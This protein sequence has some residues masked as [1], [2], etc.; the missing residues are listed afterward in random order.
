MAWIDDYF[1]ETKKSLGGP[2]QSH[3]YSDSSEMGFQSQ[4]L[5]GGQA[6]F[7]PKS[8]SEIMSMEDAAISG[9]TGAALGGPA[10]AGIMV[11]G[12]FLTNYMAQKAADERAKRD[13]AVQI[14]QQYGQDQANAFQQLMKT[15]QGALR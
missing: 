6:K 13:R 4:P 12:Q 10:A 8:E 5:S 2:E 9:G 7:T 14:E 3:L 1:K 11:G 15:Y